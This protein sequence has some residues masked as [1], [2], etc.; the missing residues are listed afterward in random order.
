MFSSGKYPKSLDE[1]HFSYV[2]LP[3]DIVQDYFKAKLGISQ[4]Y[5]RNSSAVIVWRYIDPKI[6]YL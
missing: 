4:K 6:F 2:I 5:I 1:Y 3:Q